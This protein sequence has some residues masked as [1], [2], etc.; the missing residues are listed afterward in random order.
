VNGS[1]VVNSLPSTFNSFQDYR[2]MFIPLFLHEL[3]S[4]LSR[5]V[6]EK[7]ERGNE[8]KLPVIIQEIKPRER[9]S[10]FTTFQCCS[11]L[12]ESEA[13]KD[14]GQ[15]G[16][17]VTIN[18][19]YNIGDTN[20]A[21]EIR[22][23]FGHVRE[24]NK[25]RLGDYVF[26]ENERIQR[27]LIMAKKKS[28]DAKYWVKYSIRTKTSLLGAKEKRSICITKPVIVQFLARI[29]PDL[30]KAQAMLDLPK[31]KL[32]SCIV[33]PDNKSLAV[34]AS[35]GALHPNIKD[36]A[37]FRQL[38]D[39]QRRVV[40]GVT[41][42]CLE[43]NESKISLVQGPPGTGKSKT[44]V[45]IILQLIS[46]RLNSRENAENVR[47]DKHRVPRILVCAPSNAAVD[48]LGLKLADVKESLPESKQFTFV[49]LGVVKSMHPEVQKYSFDTI[50]EKMVNS[51]IRQI[52]SSNSLEVDE[53]N[54][55]QQANRLYD[56]KIR[57]ENQGSTDL[58]AKL[59]RDYKE[60]M[61]EKDRIR[62]C[63]NKPLDRKQRHL[64]EQNAT[65]R[66][67][68]DVDI[69]LTTLSSSLNQ[70]MDNYFVKENG[71]S[72]DKDKFR[73]ISVCIMDEASQC[74]EP[75]ALIPL[76]LRFNKLVMVGDHEQLPA[77]VMSQKAKNYGYQQSLFGRLIKLSSGMSGEDC[78]SPVLRLTTQYRMHN[79]I[80][81]WPSKRFYGGLLTPGDQ[82]RDSV[83]APY[84]LLDIVAKENNDKG[85]L[86]NEAECRLAVDVAQALRK[87]TNNKHLSIGI[88]TFYA[89]QKANISLEIQ[90]R[91]IPGV[92]VNTVDGYQGSERD[93]IIISSVRSGGCSIGFLESRERLNV[94][95]TRAKLALVLIGDLNTLKTS[96]MWDEL[97][98]NARLRNVVVDMAKGPRL[99]E[100][101]RKKIA[102]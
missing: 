83:L 80:S 26:G 89:K 46:A 73:D 47:K 7:E 85:S 44:I 13:R 97:I 69:V 35:N 66:L 62:S 33:N 76:K 1:Y 54:K 38:N 36:L 24:I 43:D 31:S 60:V 15:D 74:T 81:L 65:K 21:K 101:L 42:S 50:L 20:G 72:R 100:V 29:K 18:L 77:T 96:E 25:T 82:K 14:P 98:K 8:D 11:L 22:Q 4:S 71:T 70:V 9:D 40:V 94:A 59:E 87:L 88:I 49:R 78:R 48:N 27:D 12:T 39:N 23:T 68:C 75:E 56:E 2:R 95:L 92:D 93:I 51:D 17:F 19:S 64:I 99:E 52:K 53:K 58:A 10:R 3:W 86:S 67:M 57:A 79:E 37:Q 16:T 28:K 32:F 45:G 6:A 61:K 90:N 55:Q 91:R 41:R 5:E 34:R 84:T 30:R 63:L 102:S